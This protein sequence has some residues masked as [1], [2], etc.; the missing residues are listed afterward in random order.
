MATPTNTT[1]PE[2]TEQT[3]PPPAPPAPN[4]E[5]APRAGTGEG[6]TGPRWTSVMIPAVSAE[7]IPR[8]YFGKCDRQPHLHHPLYHGLAAPGVLRAVY[9]RTGPNTGRW[10]VQCRW[11]LLPVALRGRGSQEEPIIVEDVVLEEVEVV[12]VEDD[13]DA[14]NADEGG[15]DVE[16]VQDLQDA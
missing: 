16:V 15:Q 9:I 4:L 10:T 6:A 8:D 2:T 14:E 11:D 7:A 3:N 12:V 5:A 1:Q 13:D